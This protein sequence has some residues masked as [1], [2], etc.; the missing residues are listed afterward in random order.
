MLVSS[1]LVLALVALCLD[2]IYRLL[3]LR[4]KILSINLIILLTTVFY[5]LRAMH[6][7][8]SRVSFFM[9]PKRI[10]S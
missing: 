5:P 10:P 3:S 6:V 2:L 1:Y 4:L 7:T 8:L 9:L